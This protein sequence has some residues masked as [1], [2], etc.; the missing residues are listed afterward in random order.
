[1]NANGFNAIWFILLNKYNNNLDIIDNLI[2][3]EYIDKGPLRMLILCMLGPLRHAWL[4]FPSSSCSMLPPSLLRVDCSSRFMSGG[5]G[6]PSPPS[7]ELTPFPSGPRLRPTHMSG[8]AIIRSNSLVEF[9]WMIL[10]LLF[11]SV[12]IITVNISKS[13][14]AQAPASH[15]DRFNAWR[16]NLS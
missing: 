1:M 8:T 16:W 12:F 15:W 5:P 3:F 2:T 6:P 9:D 13:H 7:L 4:F 10:W 11:M 14:T